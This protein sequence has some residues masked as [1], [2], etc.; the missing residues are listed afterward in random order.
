M[1]GD[2]PRSPHGFQ[3]RTMNRQ[4]SPLVLLVVFGMTAPVPAGPSRGSVRLGLRFTDASPTVLSLAP[5]LRR[6][7]L[8][9]LEQALKGKG[10][11]F[12]PAIHAAE[13]LTQAKHGDEVRAALPG[14]LK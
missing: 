13:A 9:V 6:R 4:A 5:E 2:S 10:D 3:R 7:C 12:W 1:A 14:R 11:D 8:D